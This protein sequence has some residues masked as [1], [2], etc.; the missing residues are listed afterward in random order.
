MYLSAWYT[1]E[2][3]SDVLA[4][5]YYDRRDT[6]FW[7]ITQSHYVSRPQGDI[8]TVEYHGEPYAYLSTSYRNDLD[9]NSDIMKHVHKHKAIRVNDVPE[10]LV[11]SHVLLDEYHG[12]DGPEDLENG[13]I[14]PIQLSLNTCVPTLQEVYDDAADKGRF[15]S[16]LEGGLA[17][18]FSQS[19]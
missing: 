15:E 13:A 11:L 1:E 19:V 9:D 8:F 6:I 10:Y 18:M 2:P 16:A 7:S 12:S 14:I 5:G 3:P 4:S 17:L